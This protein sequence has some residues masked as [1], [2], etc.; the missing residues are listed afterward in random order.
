MDQQHEKLI[1]TRILHNGKFEKAINLPCTRTMNAAMPMGILLLLQ[2]ISYFNC[3]AEYLQFSFRF[4]FLIRLLDFCCVVLMI[5]KIR[6]KITRKS[7]GR[8]FVH[9]NFCNEQQSFQ[10]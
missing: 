6:C 5:S 7:K 4:E 8:R 3:F 2:L 1:G 10:L 9:Q